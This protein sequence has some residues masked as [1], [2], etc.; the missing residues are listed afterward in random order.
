[1]DVAADIKIFDPIAEIGNGRM[2]WIVGTED[3][4]GFLH[5]VRSVYI[6]DCAV[7]R[8]V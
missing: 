6:F 8:E 2:S 1:M 3:L 5:S 7:V 4:N